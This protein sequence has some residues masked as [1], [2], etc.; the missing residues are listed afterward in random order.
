MTIL[1][2]ANGPGYRGGKR[3][4]FDEADPTDPDY[5]QESA[6]GLW[7]A[8]HSGVDV[9]VYAQGP[10]A[11]VVYGVLEQNALFH[12]IVQAL[13]RLRDASRQLTGEGEHLPDH[14]RLACSFQSE[15]G[16]DC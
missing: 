16:Q 5:L 14:D 11:E 7:S 8:T 12:V 9:P 13:P 1:G 2:Y 6:V 15:S 10:G 3:P 4:D